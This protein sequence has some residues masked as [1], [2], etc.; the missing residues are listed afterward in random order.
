V[1]TNWRPSTHLTRRNWGR[2]NRRSWYGLAFVLPGVIYFAVFFLYP[3][4]SALSWSFTSYDLINEP[5]FRGL[6]NF[7]YMLTDKHFI[8]GVV[9]TFKY[10][11][12]VVPAVFVSGFL[13]SLLFNQ[14]F[15]GR[16]IFR[17]IFFVPFVVSIVAASFIWRYIYQPTYG[18][19]PQVARFLQLPEINWLNDGRYAIWGLVIIAIW[20]VSGYYMVI[21]LAGLQNISSELYEAAAIDGAGGIARFWYITVPLMKPIMLFVLIVATI[22][23]FQAFAPALL[24]TSGGP[25][26]A[27]RVLL[28]YLYETGW[29]YL[30][31]GYASAI[32]VFMVLVLTA[33]TLLYMRLVKVET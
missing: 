24:V 28:L 8:N 12:G 29:L 18:L 15:R 10:V 11:F 14:E 33:F 27:T 4:L 30:R 2:L 16:A 32:A 5:Q 22:G 31:F 3:V 19:W 23:A 1:E 17:T 21:F 6:D 20:R 13:L 25:A 7:R 9:V 26:G